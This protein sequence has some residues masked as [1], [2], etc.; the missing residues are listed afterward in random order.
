MLDAVPIYAHHAL[1]EST[2]AVA[3]VERLA[4]QQELQAALQAV[5][6]FKEAET[7]Q[8]RAH[9]RILSKRQQLATRV[10]PED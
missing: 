7:I 1:Q 5:A 3:A 9:Q 6:A 2:A 4:L 8:V 10:A